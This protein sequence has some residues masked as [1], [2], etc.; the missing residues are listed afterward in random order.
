MTIVLT[1]ET[2]LHDSDINR[3]ST[4]GICILNFSENKSLEQL[5]L[6]ICAVLKV[7]S[8]KQC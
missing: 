1:S 5:H 6:E 7:E 4:L 3:N 8:M 2:A